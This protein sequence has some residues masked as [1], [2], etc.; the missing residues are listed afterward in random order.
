MLKALDCN[1][2][3]LKVT[4]MKYRDLQKNLTCKNKNKKNY[5]AVKFFFICETEYS[6]ASSNPTNFQ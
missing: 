1:L 4:F 5:A 3:A 2:R 6:N